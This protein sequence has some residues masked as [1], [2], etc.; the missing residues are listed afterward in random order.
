MADKKKRLFGGRPSWEVTPFDTYY[1]AVLKNLMDERNWT[2]AQLA[3]HLTFTR[4][5]I[6]RRKAE[7]NGVEFVWDDIANAVTTQT[8]HDAVNLKT[9]PT[10]GRIYEFTR[11]FGVSPAR[12]FPQNDWHPTMEEG[13]AMR[14]EQLTDEQKQILYSLAGNL[15]E[16]NVRE[17][18]AL[19]EESVKPTPVTP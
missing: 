14:W 8:A 7:K 5:E 2:Q 9:Q 16:M 3:Q 17:S 13:L 4:K 18:V 12:F 15:I 10:L 6:A 11:V 19:E 1:G